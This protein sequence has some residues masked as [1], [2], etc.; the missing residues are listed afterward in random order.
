[1]NIAKTLPATIGADLYRRLTNM[2][3]TELALLVIWRLIRHARA[4]QRRL[5]HAQILRRD[6]G[7][8]GALHDEEAR[9]DAVDI[10]DGRARD[11]AAAPWPGQNRLLRTL[12]AN[13]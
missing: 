5:H 9:L 2:A 7:V 12:G 4:L 13:S 10:V 3:S 6:V 1:M 8:A 11:S